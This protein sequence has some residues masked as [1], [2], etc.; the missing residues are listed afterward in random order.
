MHKKATEYLCI[1]P[2]CIENFKKHL[3]IGRKKVYYIYKEIY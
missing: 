2:I 3:E 1:L